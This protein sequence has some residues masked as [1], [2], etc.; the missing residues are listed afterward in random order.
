MIAFWNRKEV[1]TGSSLQKF[2]KARNRLK[3]GKI[4]YKPC[5][6]ISA[7]RRKDGADA[8]GVGATY[9]IYVHAN[10]YEQARTLLDNL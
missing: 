6:A 7:L 10:D 4:K 2:N 9:T 1:F 3:T 5:T 8:D